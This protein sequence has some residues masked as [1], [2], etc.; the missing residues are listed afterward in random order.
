MSYLYRSNLTWIDLYRLSN[1]K[2]ENESKLDGTR[3]ELG[4]EMRCEAYLRFFVESINDLGIFCA[5]R[6]ANITRILVKWILSVSIN[7]FFE[8]SFEWLFNYLDESFS[9]SHCDCSIENQ[10]SQDTSGYL[11]SL[12]STL[13]ISTVHC[14]EKHRIS[15]FSEASR[16]RTKT[17]RNDPTKKRY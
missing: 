15:P 2:I 16:E 6:E 14:R 3:V 13:I 11:F 10:I 4:C 1:W 7:V 5:N 12:S 9:L 8:K 17:P